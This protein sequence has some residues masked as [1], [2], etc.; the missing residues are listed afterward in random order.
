MKVIVFLFGLLPL[1][2]L[3]WLGLTDG[4]GANPI[5]FITRSTGTWALVFLCLTLAM[6][7]LRLL[8]GAVVWIRYRR[9]LGLFTFFYA[10]MHF[11]IWLWLDQNIDVVAMLKDVAKRPF[12]TMGFASLVLLTPLALTS[13]HW[14]QK[15]LGRRWAVLHRLIYIVACTAILHYWWHKAA[16]NDVGT[17][18]I[19]AAVLAT[20]LCCRLSYVRNILQHLSHQKKT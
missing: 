20:L 18:S 2:R 1:D 9:M 15:R 11:G 8:T 3:I 4:L 12:I 14:A 6:T 16:K 5:E 19:Y 13:N 10:S 17:V 7:P